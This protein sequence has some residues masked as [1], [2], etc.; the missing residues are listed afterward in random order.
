VQYDAFISYN[1]SADRRLAEA[2]QR[3]LYRFAAPFPGRRAVSL[4]RDET[5]L[6]ASPGLWP[7]IERALD[8]SAWFILLASPEAAAGRRHGWCCERRRGA[9]RDGWR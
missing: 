4:F 1:H 5:H 3:G 2:L 9:A 7:T 8:A 6:S